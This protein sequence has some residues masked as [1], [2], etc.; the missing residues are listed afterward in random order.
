[1][2]GATLTDE[3]QH[4]LWVPP[5]YAHGFVVLSEVALFEYKCTDLYH[6]EDEIGVCWN[7]PT[8]AI[9]W[10]VENPTVSDRDA[11]LPNLADLN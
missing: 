3:N 7:D 4:Q 11:S 1:M 8:A 2:Y 10:P 6:P 9:D 5:G